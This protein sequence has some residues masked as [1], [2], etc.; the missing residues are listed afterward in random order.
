MSMQGM[1]LFCQRAKPSLLS[2]LGQMNLFMPAEDDYKLRLA[3]FSGA[4]HASCMFF[5][6]PFCN[7]LTLGS[8]GKHSRVQGVASSHV[9]GS[10]V[11]SEQLQW[12]AR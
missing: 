10:S 12:C 1:K 6:D 3:E 4:S 11:S 2:S 9:L 8:H 5:Y 7:V